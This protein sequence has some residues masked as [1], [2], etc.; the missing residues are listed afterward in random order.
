[1]LAWASAGALSR[2]PPQHHRVFHGNS[3]WNEFY[4][5]TGPSTP[6]RWHTFRVDSPMK[7]AVSGD[8]E[9]AP[10]VSGGGHRAVD[11]DAD[12]G[13]CLWNVN[14]ARPR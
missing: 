13:E 8:D 5:W 9:N 12:G 3:N 4:D 6:W 14:P 2:A 7:G 10:V 1:M 11:L